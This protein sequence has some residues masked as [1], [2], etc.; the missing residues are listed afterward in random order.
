MNNLILALLLVFSGVY[1]TPGLSTNTILA[2]KAILFVFFIITYKTKRRVLLR[3]SDFFPF[4]IV[5]P[6][7]VVTSQTHGI[8]VLKYVFGLLLGLILLARKNS[9]I[10]RLQFWCRPAIVAFVI[11]WFVVSSLE[12]TNPLSFTSFSTSGF[13]T[14]STGWAIML[15]QLIALHMWASR[16]RGITFWTVLFSLVSIQFIS[17]GRS[18]T[19]STLA[20]LFFQLPKRFKSISLL[21]IF[22]LAYSD[23]SNSESSVL[24]QFLSRGNSFDL[25]SISTNR[26][27]QYSYLSHVHWTVYILGFGFLGSQQFLSLH[28]GLPLEF[29]NQ[30][31]RLLLD[32][33]IIAV[34]LILLL[35]RFFLRA[36]KQVFARKEP[37]FLSQF[38]LSSL[39]I[40]LLE[41]NF[42]VGAFLNSIVLWFFIA[43]FNEKYNYSADD[44]PALSS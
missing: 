32:H 20:L 8:G 26:W 29:H 9:N 39:P 36:I 15:F 3:R 43:L 24:L 12:P 40:W 34:P 23:V 33:G 31:I 27:V 44:S 14:T 22:I 30:F 1:W 38:L 13:N 42:L 7:F 17:G 5:L 11:L 35:F 41:P 25:N 18:A 4:V 19:V 6:F 37:C 10:E 28:Q 2:L 21:V 16:K